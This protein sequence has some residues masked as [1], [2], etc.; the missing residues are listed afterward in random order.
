MMAAAV[1]RV[2]LGV[3]L[4]SENVLEGGH[5]DGYDDGRDDVC[6]HRPYANRRSMPVHFP[7]PRSRGRT[8]T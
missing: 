8:L 4:A 5:H 7:Y 2:H 6:H 1:Q 3:R